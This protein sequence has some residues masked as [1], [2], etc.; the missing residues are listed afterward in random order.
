MGF[1]SGFKGLMTAGNR[2]CVSK[3]AAEQY[4]VKANR[5][6][7]TFVNLEWLQYECAYL[8]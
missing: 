2:I 5:V 8:I 7:K 3:D 1:N 4:K 6:T